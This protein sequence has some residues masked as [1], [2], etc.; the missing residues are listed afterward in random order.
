MPREDLVERG[1]LVQSA[2]LSA[3]HGMSAAREAIEL[4]ERLGARLDRHSSQPV[5]PE[6]LARADY[7]LAM[8]ER[9]QFSLLDEYP[10]FA[11]RVR[12][13]STEGTDIE[14][15]IGAGAAEYRRCCDQIMGYL[16][17]LLNEVVPAG[18]EG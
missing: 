10:E 4:M 6:L 17:E 11:S 5:T 3:T 14:D 2:G 8:T 12:L 16:K 18:R 9:H 13:L 15:P 7:V 1:F